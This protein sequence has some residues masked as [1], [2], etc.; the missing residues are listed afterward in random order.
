MKGSHAHLA[1]AGVDIILRVTPNAR[2]RAI[3]GDAPDLRAYVIAPPADGAANAAVQD[4]LAEA[5]GVAK[6]RLVLV[7]GVTSRI[8]RFRLL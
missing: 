4:L 2:R 5:L 1:I 6:T 7:S 8:K 3:E